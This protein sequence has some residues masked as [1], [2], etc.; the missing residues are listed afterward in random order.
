MPQ[1]RLGAEER[2]RHFS[3]TE[4][5]GSKAGHNVRMV[6]DPWQRYPMRGWVRANARGIG[7]DGYLVCT[8]EFV[9][10]RPDGKLIPEELG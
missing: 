2:V 6:Q 1:L 3:M 4:A 10:E 7:E 9:T 5:D 8:I